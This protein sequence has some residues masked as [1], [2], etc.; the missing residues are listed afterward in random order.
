MYPN[1]HIYIYMYIYIYIGIHEKVYQNLTNFELK[2]AITTDFISMAITS[3]SYAAGH[4]REPR[5]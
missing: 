4:R 3:P 5:R 2:C 1:V